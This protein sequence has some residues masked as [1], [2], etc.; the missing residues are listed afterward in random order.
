M[1]D[2]LWKSVEGPDN[3]Y[4]CGDNQVITMKKNSDVIVLVKSNY[5]CTAY[6][7]KVNGKPFKCTFER[8][9]EQEC[10]QHLD[11]VLTDFL[12]SSS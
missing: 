2:I 4:H 1:D 11:K 6:V 3:A 7:Q 5:R 12:A 10:S 8:G 9:S